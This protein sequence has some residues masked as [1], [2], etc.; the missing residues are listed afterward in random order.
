MTGNVAEK[1]EPMIDGYANKRWGLA[2]N[3]VPLKLMFVSIY[4]C[5]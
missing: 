5:G 3:K 1:V 2:R 4:V